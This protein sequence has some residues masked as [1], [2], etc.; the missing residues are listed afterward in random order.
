MP[1]LSCSPG[2]VQWVSVN[3]GCAVSHLRCFRYIVTA[4]APSSLPP[5]AGPRKSLGQYFL[6]DQR[7]LG[8]ILAAGDLDGDDFVVEIGPG[9]GA[10]TR[11]LLP[12]VA[13]LLALE[14][15]ADLAS[16]LPARLGNPENLTVVAA[17]AR[18]VDLAPFLGVTEQY[19]VMAN[20]PYYAANPII[21]RFLESPR[22]PSRMVVMV[23]REVA[24]GMTASPGKM[25]L[26]SVATQV[27]AQARIVCQVPPAA[28][29]PSPKVHSAVVRM[30]VL[31]QPVVSPH[32]APSFFSLVR[33]GF[34]APRKQLRNSLG[35]GLGRPGPEVAQLLA[36]A[37]VDAGRRAE[38]L[39]LEEWLALFRVAESHEFAGIG[40]GERVGKEDR[41]AG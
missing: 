17:D 2:N 31:P 39:A 35:H 18:T 14:L 15:D 25:S 16:A 8:R 7:I 12:Q 40:S 37:G 26:L 36:S 9:R 38:T 33:A 3:G 28:F 6:V 34:S 10:L 19:K 32:E 30:D 27:Y 11:K 20:L 5:P 4:T 13:R 24:E 29:R 41:V 1:G 21:R 22:P 23:Q